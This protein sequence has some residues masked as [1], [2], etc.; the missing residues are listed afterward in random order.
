VAI[1][2]SCCRSATPLPNNAFTAIAQDAYGRKSTNTVVV[3][4]PSSASY[5]YDSNGNLLYDGN[6]A[7]QWDDENELTQI[8]VT[9]AWM[10]Q[11]SYDGKLRRRIRK[12]FSWVN[13]AWV[14]TNEVHSIYDGNL[15]IQERDANNL[16]LASYTRG[17]DSSGSFE[18]AGGIGGLLARTDNSRLNTADPLAEAYYHADGNGNITCLVYTNQDVGARYSYDAFGNTLSAS[19]PLAGVNLYQFS[20][21]ELHPNSGI[22]YYLYRFYDAG[23]QR[24]LNRDPIEEEG[25][26]NLYT[27]EGND[28]INRLDSFGLAAVTKM[29][30][31][32]FAVEV[33]KCEIVRVIGHGNPQGWPKFLFPK[34]KLGGCPA[35]GGFIGCYASGVNN[36]MNG[37][38]VIPGSP[39]SSD[40]GLWDGQ[41]SPYRNSPDWGNAVQQTD[42]G[43]K[44]LVNNWLNN[45]SK[46]CPSVT[47]VEVDENGNM[48]ST[49]YTKPI[50]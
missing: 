8:T 3:N 16:P 40:G 6:R 23:L 25:G 33:G 50:P 24:W 41:V 48:K 37:G 18:G 34:G 13:S 31:G 38:T 19:G 17:L 12:E 20:S 35:A 4:L 22:S 10:S 26:R 11:F 21:K 44:S 36:G 7:F 32:G 30:N 1:A 49:K 39:R 43:I 14:E 47:V 15:V 46:C 27:F 2:P 28:S 5:Q 9:N 45:Q 42:A 29:P